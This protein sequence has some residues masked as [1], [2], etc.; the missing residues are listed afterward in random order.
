VEQLAVQTDD[1]VS[2]VL[3]RSMRSST[4][5]A[6]ANFRLAWLV[7]FPRRDRN[8]VARRKHMRTQAGIELIPDN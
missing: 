4:N 1:S 6:D 3:P 2:K 5:I 7:N 8:S